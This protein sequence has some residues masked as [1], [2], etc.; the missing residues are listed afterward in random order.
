MY[1][2]LEH[3]AQ[4]VRPTPDVRFNYYG[5]ERSVREA[6]GEGLVTAGLTDMMTDPPL[7]VGA[8]DAGLDPTRTDEPGARPATDP[9]PTPCPA[10]SPAGPGAKGGLVLPVG[11]PDVGCANG[12]LAKS[13]ARKPRSAMSAKS[14]A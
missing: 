2:S 7:R 1:L 11:D 4:S 14:C 6:R 9:V 12:F 13:G 5:K 10:T 3:A 8:T